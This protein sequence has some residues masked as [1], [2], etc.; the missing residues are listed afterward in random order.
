LF[1]IPEPLLYARV[2]GVVRDGDLV[3]MELELI[4]PE[5]FFR[6][7]ESARRNFISALKKRLQVFGA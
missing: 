4:D 6:F 5:L 1:D 2:D 3:L 7:S